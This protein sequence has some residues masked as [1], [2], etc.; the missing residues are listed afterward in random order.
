M[1]SAIN[2][3]NLV[4]LGSDEPEAT[5]DYVHSILLYLGAFLAFSGLRKLLT[6]WEAG[7]VFYQNNG[8][9]TS[10]YRNTAIIKVVG[11]WE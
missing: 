9:S 4:S 3:Y 2:F 10:E 1:S 7:E 11:V 6:R 8:V 5:T